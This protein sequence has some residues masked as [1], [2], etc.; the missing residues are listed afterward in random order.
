MLVLG[1]SI[2]LF[3]YTPVEGLQLPVVIGVIVTLALGELV[4]RF[5]ENHKAR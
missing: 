5:A 3:M 1:L 2:V 4:I